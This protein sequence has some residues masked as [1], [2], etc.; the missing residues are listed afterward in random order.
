MPGDEKRDFNHFWLKSQV[1]KEYW[2]HF[3]AGNIQVNND[4]SRRDVYS[5]SLG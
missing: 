4:L 3:K 2:E 1:F 5:P